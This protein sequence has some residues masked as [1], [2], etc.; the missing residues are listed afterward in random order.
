MLNVEQHR[1]TDCLSL[2]LIGRSCPER[3][4]LAYWEAVDRLDCTLKHRDAKVWRYMMRST[5][6]LRCV[7][8]GL[9]LLYPASSIRKRIYVMFC[10]LETESSFA[11][12]FLPVQRSCAYFM[13]IVFRGVRAVFAAMVG[14][15]LVKVWKLA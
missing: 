6:I 13:I 8:A 5:L 14:L 11:S 4:A 10:V 7:D 3:A 9:A 12:D 2:Y 1:E 15:F